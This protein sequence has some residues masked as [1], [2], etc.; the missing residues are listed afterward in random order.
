MDFCF[1]LVL[2]F[3][4]SPNSPAMLFHTPGSGEQNRA[5]PTNGFIYGTPITAPYYEWEFSGGYRKA[6]Y[7][8]DYEW[9]DGKWRGTF[10]TGLIEFFDSNGNKVISY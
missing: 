10:P 9:R 2:L 4:N 5:Y 6:T 3:S 7:Y 1:S 8:L